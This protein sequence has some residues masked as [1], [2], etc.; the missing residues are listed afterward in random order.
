MA[1]MFIQDPDHAPGVPEAHQLFPQDLHAHRVAIRFGKLVCREHRDPESAHG[2]PHGGIRP[3]TADL[4]IVFSRQH[5]PLPWSPPVFA[6][7]RSFFQG[8]NYGLAGRLSRVLARIHPLCRFAPQPG[9]LRWMI[10][11]ALAGG[12][13]KFEMESAWM[14]LKARG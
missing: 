8:K 6:T 10:P 12:A 11:S 5:G 14:M 9:M 13:P 3:H 4:Q 1:A 7:G 2:L